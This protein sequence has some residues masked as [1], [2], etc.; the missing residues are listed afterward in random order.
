MQKTPAA[1]AFAPPGNTIPAGAILV[2]PDGRL[3]PGQPRR[4]RPGNLPGPWRKPG[5]RHRLDPAGRRRD[6]RVLRPAKGTSG[7]GKIRLSLLLDGEHNK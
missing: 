1:E 4:N 7:E 3:L 6:R 5:L 2:V